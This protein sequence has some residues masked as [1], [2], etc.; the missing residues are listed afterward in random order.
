MVASAAIAA[1]VL[2][3]AGP[4][5][6]TGVSG[7]D[8]MLRGAFGALTALAAFRAQR[9]TVSVAGFG[10][11]AASV[12]SVSALGGAFGVAGAGVALGSQRFT[13]VRRSLRAVAGA[14]IAQ[15]ILRFGDAG[16]HGATALLGLA[17]V[18]PLAVEAVRRSPPAHRRAILLSCLGLTLVG[19][20]AAAGTGGAVLRAKGQVDAAVDAMESGLDALRAADR[21]VAL[22]RFDEAVLDFAEAERSLEAWWGRGGRA[23]PVISQNAREVERLSAVGYDLAQA[24]ATATREANLDNATLDDGRVDLEALAGLE[25][26]LRDSL[27]SLG[28]ARRSATGARSP[29]LLAPLD[30][31]REALVK[32]VDGA[33]FDARRALRAAQV[34]PGLLGGDG[35]RRYFVAFVTPA[36]AR[37]SGG[38]VGNYGELTVTDGKVEMT[39]F[40][41]NS[42]LNAAGDAASRAAR[43]IVAP[44]DYLARYGDFN[45]EEYWQDITFSP[46]FPSV[47]QAIESLYPQSGGRELDGVISVDPVAIAGLLRLT[48][49]V[50]VPELGKQLT[51]ENAAEVL[52]HEQ[53]ERFAEKAERVDFLE[54]AALVVFDRLTSGK[55]PGPGKFAGALGPAVRQDRIKM[56]SVHPEEQA[57]LEEIGLSGEMLPVAGQ[58]LGVYSGTASQSKVDAF[59]R[60]EVS[61]DAI[62]DPGT[63]RTDALV[64]VTLHNDAPASGLPGYVIGGQRTPPGVNLSYFAVYSP[65][66][67]VAAE[68]DGEPLTLEEEIERERWV[69]SGYVEI[70]PGDSVTVRVRLAGIVAMRV[71]DRGVRFRLDVARQALVEPDQVTVRV[72]LTPGW[73][74]QATGKAEIRRS[75]TQSE[76]L[77]VDTRL[78]DRT[79]R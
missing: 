78:V 53:Y 4:G 38:I 7:V 50:D 40:G 79:K 5:A 33:I 16:F 67:L 12:V 58:F 14:L 68:A 66:R 70:Q 64:T 71:E 75:L 10:V 65:L 69:L 30:E 26:P 48:G 3:A 17:V 76:D 11:V 8:L 43:Q 13:G 49:P 22:E 47:A 35:P 32:R 6:P 60:R 46:D 28:A 61:Y 41:R 24:A 19:G 18:A 77:V 44:D 2:A 57:F 52:L 51:A 36:E 27:E 21:D 29:W 20:V 31:A 63:G 72:R 54:T 34:T 39:A 42:D 25:R 73:E 1:A 62:V 23:V 56:H 59:L 55:L 74:D 45:I 9:P 15:G 37:P